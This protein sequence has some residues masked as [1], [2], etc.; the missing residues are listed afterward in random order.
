MLD[1][2]YAASKQ[3]VAND[4]GKVAV[5]AENIIAAGDDCQA[6][7]DGCM[8]A[9][10]M[11]ENEDGGRCICS[12]KISEFDSILAEIEKIDASAQAM[13]T[14]GIDAI[15]NGT[16]IQTA[17]VSTDDDETDSLLS[18][19]DEDEE[20]T[21]D[22]EEEPATGDGLRAQAHELCI[23]RIPECAEKI[24]F[25]SSMYGTR[26][27]SDCT[28]YENSLKQRKTQS[29][30][31]LAAAEKGIRDA[32]LDKFN[33]ANKFDLA[34]C[35]TEFKRCMATTAECGDDFSK[36]V[37]IPTD[38]GEKYS[39]A[40]ATSQIDISMAT[41]SRL[42][43]KKIICESVTKQCQSV[44]D[45]VWGTFLTQYAT[46][47]SSAELIAMDNARQ[48]CAG[49]VSQCF[50]TA[51]RDNVDPDDPDGSYDLC[52]TRPE[53]MLSFCENE[54]AACGVDT[55]SDTA[56]RQS[57]LWDYVVA[58]LAAMRVNS[59]AEDVKSCLTAD[60]RCGSDYAKCIGVDTD[61]IIRM[62]PYE[63][64]PGCQQVY[65]ETDIRGDA[66]YDEVARLVQGIFVNIDNALF[67]ACERALDDAMVRV[68]GATDNCNNLTVEE[69][70]GAGALAY[71]LCE[72]TKNN[73]EIKFDYDKCR[74]NIDGITDSDPAD[75]IDGTIDGII[76]WGAIKY[77]PDTGNVTSLDEYFE[78][79]DIP[80]ARDE[81]R[82]RIGVELDALQNKITTAIASVESDAR[83]QWCMTGREVPGVDKSDIDDGAGRFPGLTKQARILIAHGAIAAANE[84]YLSKYDELNGQLA[85]DRVVL[86]ELVAKARGEKEQ[87]KY[88]ENSRIACVALAGG[89][90]AAE[91]TEEDGNIG[92]SSSERSDYKETL[93]TEFNPDTLV[94]KR[95]RKSTQCRTMWGGGRCMKWGTESEKCDEIKF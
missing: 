80:A 81:V 7:Y 87:E 5:A 48:N 71:Q 78:N 77:D 34:G 12:N 91:V 21:S 63:S 3:N 27:R 37:E 56:A 26:I 75:K 8:D 18:L 11:S 90:T 94:C 41:Y 62:C 44:A 13:A 93:T 38:D 17:S 25:A 9:F 57:M 59:C 22:S 60:D 74:A 82:T 40:G 54:L 66:V 2:V 35:V 51:C 15:K 69:G 53:T 10:C 86:G 73:N 65:G 72:F 76:S 70:M 84:N 19:W 52:L 4:A 45:Q 83:V 23:E 30:Q 20:V 47:I 32:A 61:S 55:S 89:K 24:T 33:D 95:C 42:E 79:E 16:D 43:T 64:L 36:C 46:N 92:T 85:R 67:T 1:A 50:Q 88:R 68:C 6:K 31:K 28:A 39:I 29:E 58:R 49:T 14:T